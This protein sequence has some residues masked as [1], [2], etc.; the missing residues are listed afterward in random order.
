MEELKSCRICGRLFES[1]KSINVCPVCIASEDTDFI[2]IREYLYEHPHSSIYEVAT[3]LGITINKIKSFLREGR[4]EIVEKDN[5]F[6]TC[7]TCGK[8][9]HSGRYC[10]ECLKHNVSEVKGVFSGNPPSRLDSNSK[11]KQEETKLKF[12]S[13]GSNNYKK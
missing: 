9:I 13:N 12:H 2:K 10:D 11:S 7:E 8:P 5:Q 1:D 6:L 3:V 4:I